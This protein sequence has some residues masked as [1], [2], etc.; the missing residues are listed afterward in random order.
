MTLPRSEIER[1]IIESIPKQI[2]GDPGAAIDLDENLFVSGRIDS[3]GI[4][5]LIAHLEETLEIQ[6]PPSD[7]VPDNFRTVRVM[8]SYLS[9]LDS[10]SDS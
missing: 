10:A 8:A 6:I 4:M 5:R 3:V 9:G 7:L 1:I 2:L